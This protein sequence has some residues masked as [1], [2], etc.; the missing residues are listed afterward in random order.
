MKFE[1]QIHIALADDGPGPSSRI[2]ADAVY[3]PIEAGCCYEEDLVGARPPWAEF[4]LD[5]RFIFE[6]AD[7][8]T[9][10]KRLYDAA[11]AIEALEGLRAAALA[12]GAAWTKHE[13]WPGSADPESVAG[14]AEGAVESVKSEPAGTLFEP[15]VQ[16]H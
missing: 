8:V 14:W 2:V 16:E 3:G 1:F 15:F 12:H 10:R 11:A 9:P 7:T 4:F 5:C 13:K 6:S